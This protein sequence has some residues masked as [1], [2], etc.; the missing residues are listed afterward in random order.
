MN[1]LFC[2]QNGFYPTKGGVQRFCYTLSEYLEGQ[3]HTSYFLS[4]VRDE[5]FEEI[6]D[7]RYFTLPKH[8]DL[9]HNDNVR[10]YESLLSNLK[11]SI[12]INNEASND[13]YSFFAKKNLSGIKCIAIYHTDPTHNL[14]KSEAHKQKIYRSFTSILR[15]VKRRFLLINI[16][17]KCDALVVLSNSFVFKIE[18][19]LLL[20]SKKIRSI[21]NFT[22]LP[23]A[24]SHSDKENIVLYVGRLDKD[25]QIDILLSTW[26]K[27]AKKHG[28]WTLHILGDGTED[29]SLKKLVRKQGIQK[30]TFLGRTDPEQWYE[31]AKVLCLPSKYE[32]FGL[33]LVEAMARGVV[34]IAFNNWASLKDI[35][36]NEL[37]GITIEN[38]S[39]NGL[40]T[41][42]E[43][44]M[45][46]EVLR[47]KMSAQAIEKSKQ[48]S[49][50]VAGKKWEDLMLNLIQG[51]S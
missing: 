38:N 50:K 1:I 13:R 16:L 46:D 24:C 34:P 22:K 2:Y 17:A 29:K 4:L 27:L 21:S 35:I 41:A 49:I 28:N 30:V 11:I 12:I 45:T 19:L 23:H 43:R 25:K 10:Y 6:S 36:D 31:K 3:G 8:E 48:F 51:K 37:N 47:N 44:L 20:K 15:R 5:S 7:N 26:N 33:V 9:Y 42:L 14:Y 32:G 39:K 40:Q 18:S